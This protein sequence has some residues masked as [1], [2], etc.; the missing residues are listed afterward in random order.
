[1]LRRKQYI[2]VIALLF[3]P[4]LPTLLVVVIVPPAEQNKLNKT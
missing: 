2:T 3:Y 1:M 4:I